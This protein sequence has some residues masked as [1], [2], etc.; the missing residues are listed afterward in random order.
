MWVIGG[1]ASGTYKKD[2]WYSTDGVTWT[3]ATANAAFDGRMW[4]KSVV[5]N[6][7]MWVIGGNASGIHKN[8][9]WYST[10]G[11]TWT[12]ATGSAAFSARS[13]LASIVYNDKMWVIGGNSSGTYKNDVWY[14]TDGVTWTQA[15]GSA[16]FSERVWHAS[17]VY[18][19]KMWVIG[20]IVSGN[21]LNDVWYST[22]GVTWTQATGSAAFSGRYG[23]ASVVY[24]NKMWVI[25]GNASGT[26]K[27]DVWYSSEAYYNTVIFN[28]T[29]L[30]ATKIYSGTTTT[31]NNQFSHFI[32]F[33]DNSTGC[34]VQSKAPQSLITTADTFVSFRDNTGAEIGSIAGTGVSGV[35]AYNTFTGAH[36][37]VIEGDRTNLRLLDPLEISGGGNLKEWTYNKKEIKE[38]EEDMLDSKGN[39]VIEEYGTGTI[40]LTRVKKIK[41]MK[42]VT[43]PVTLNLPPKPQL[44]KLKRCTTRKSPNVVGLYAGT[45][46]NGR[47]MYFGLGTAICRVI[48]LGENIKLNDYLMT[49]DFAGYLERQPDIW[50]PGKNGKLESHRIPEDFSIVRASEEIIWEDGEQSRE[51]ACRIIGG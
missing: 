49:S 35:I 3:Q 4:H 13:E 14:S 6:N 5:Y 46:S 1:N 12:Q 44:V 51:I 15:T 37:C 20:G 22:D 43:I 45:D 47:D 42:E 16:A 28:E 31:V 34:V 30:Y 19:N 17:V 36:A 29:G 27:N 11:V 21:Y 24:N 33:N 9:V 8:D 40:T 50:L 39:P 32:N 25:G 2:V 26:Y 41:V 18:N 10:D 38:V 23:H 7:K 48:N